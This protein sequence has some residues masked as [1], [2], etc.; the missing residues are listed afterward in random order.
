MAILDEIHSE[1]MY[2]T[3]NKDILAYLNSR[4]NPTNNPEFN[5][6]SIQFGI[7]SSAGINKD[8]SDEYGTDDDTAYPDYFVFDKHRNET[9]EYAN[10]NVIEGDAISRK[11]IVAVFRNDAGKK[12][13]EVTLGMLNSP[14]TIGQRTKENG[15]YIYPE[16]GALIES[17]PENP[18]GK[19][20]FDVCMKAI[21]VCKAKNYTDLHNLFKAF[22]M[23][24][25]AFVP[26][27]PK[28][29]PFNLAQKKNYGPRVI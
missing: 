15:D 9:S 16:V 29:A 6:A 25:N 13:F 1:L 12:I 5:F 2:T 14:L 27:H 17:L 20:I 23:T 3:E 24:S 11:S 26:L 18:T 22:L 21:E 10:P 4:L 7:K 19:D 28:N 8:S